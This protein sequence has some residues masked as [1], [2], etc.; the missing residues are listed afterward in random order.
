MP[1][2]TRRE[3]LAVAAAIGAELAW[4]RKAPAASK[5]PW[6]E[7]RD[8]YAE[9]VASAEPDAESVILWTRRPFAN[10]KDGRLHLEVAEDKAFTQVVSQT[11]VTVSAESDWTCRVLAAGLRPATE[12]WYRFSDDEGNGSRIGRT[13]TAPR[14]RDGRPIRFA[15]VRYY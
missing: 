12:Y 6:R 11:A 14:E 4:S 9:G 15:F 3:F 5:L 10:A 2:I 13:L 1:T 7:R 8:L